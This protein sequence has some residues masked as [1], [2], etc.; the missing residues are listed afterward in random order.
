[1]DTGHLILCN[2]ISYLD[3]CKPDC[4]PDTE[5]LPLG[6]DTLRLGPFLGT[7]FLTPGRQPLI[8]SASLYFGLFQEC[9]I[10][11]MVQYVAL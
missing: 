11:G 10:K 9:S 4:S 6:G 3:S 2:C 7:P 1:M 5:L 8:S